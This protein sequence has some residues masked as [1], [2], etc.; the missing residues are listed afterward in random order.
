MRP[1]T[2]SCFAPRKGI[3]CGEG[4]DAAP[5]GR[6]VRRA[7][8]RVGQRVEGR[9][10]LTSWRRPANFADGRSRTVSWVTGCPDQFPLYR[11]GWVVAF[12][13]PQ[14]LNNDLPGNVNDR[15][16]VRPARQRRDQTGT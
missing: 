8:C 12:S 1:S 14:H 5:N 3:N 10:R 4:G 15:I 11:E 7:I 2:A 16:P 9:N 13:I 6:R